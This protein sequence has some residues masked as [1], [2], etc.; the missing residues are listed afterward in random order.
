LHAKSVK[1]LLEGSSASVT[2]I[3]VDDDGSTRAHAGKIYHLAAGSNS[4]DLARRLAKRIRQI[5][6]VLPLYYYFRNSIGLTHSIWIAK[7][8]STNHAAANLAPKADHALGPASQDK[9]NLVGEFTL[10]PHLLEILR[11]KDFGEL[12]Q[13]IDDCLKGRRLRTEDESLF[14]SDPQTLRQYA[15]IHHGYE[16]QWL[17]WSKC[18]DQSVRQ[19]ER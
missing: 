5:E 6:I 4:L 16:F 17:L 9:P 14:T 7:H 3:L 10:K 1:S 15:R 12:R 11:R 18:M 2:L 8:K 13:L 19:I